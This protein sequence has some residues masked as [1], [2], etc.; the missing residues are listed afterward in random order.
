MPSCFRADAPFIADNDLQTR[1]TCGAQEG[2][3]EV[4]VELENSGTV[5]SVTQF[6][7]ANRGDFPVDLQVETSRDGTTWEDGWRGPGALRALIGSLDDPKRLPVRVDFAPREAR[8]VR[9]R[10]HG[11]DSR[12]YWSIAELTVNAPVS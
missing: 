9:L 12:Y 4:V 7:G 8:F 2:D 5:A 1:W 6:L 10:Q 3:Q 11:R